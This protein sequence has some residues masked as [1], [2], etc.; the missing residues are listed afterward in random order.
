MRK[1]LDASSIVSVYFSQIGT[2]VLFII[3]APPLLCVVFLQADRRL[4]KAPLVSQLFP[5]LWA[6]PH[7]ADAVSY[8]HLDVYKRQP[9]DRS[10]KASDSPPYMRHLRV[11]DIVPV[12]RQTST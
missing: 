5:F 10:H 2:S 12:N 3:Y 11:L 7:H 1:Y 9:L 4:W 6:E 8:T